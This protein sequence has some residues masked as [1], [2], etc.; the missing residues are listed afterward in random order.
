MAS[1]WSERRVVITGLGA[2]TPLGHQVDAFWA[3]LLNG[4]CGVDKIT[5]FDASQFDCADCR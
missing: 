3:N 2:V 1:N 5:R 4:Q